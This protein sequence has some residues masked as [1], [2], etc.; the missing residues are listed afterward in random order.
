MKAVLH[1]VVL[2]F[3]GFVLLL[4]AGFPWRDPVDPTAGP[5]AE[6]AP[7]AAVG[8]DSVVQARLATLRRIET[9]ATYLGHSLQETDSMLRRWRSRAGRP[10]GIYVS[11]E[12]APGYSPQHGEAARRAF[13]RW[14]RVGAIPIVFD[15]V[16]DSSRAEVLVRW[17]AAFNVDRSGQ[18]DV[19]WDQ[20]GWIR[21]AV[22]TLATRS[23]EGWAITPEVAYTVALHEIGHL[24]GLGHSDDPDD[25]MFPTTGIQ[26]LTSRDRRTA[27][28]LYA[29]RPGSLRTP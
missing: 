13:R 18:A 3:A 15:F 29:L 24:L 12:T 25:L 14:E 22:L 1:V 9:S 6:P 20:D 10:L 23:H 5:V 16:R 26:D 2:L 19:V 17:V 27:R 4:V 11:S 7:T 8:K 28:L 21:S